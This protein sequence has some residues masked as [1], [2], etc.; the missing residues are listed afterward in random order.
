MPK[1]VRTYVCILAALSFGLSS[2]AG[3]QGPLPACEWQ[4]SHQ[5]LS[6]RASPL[7]SVIL[8]MPT[9]TATICYSRPSARGRSVFD[10]LAPF[11]KVWRTGANEPTTLRLSRKAT[12]G[13]VSLAEEL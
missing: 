8:V 2:S 9:L 10:S 4:G 13:G 1:H 6:T 11:G 12:V 5:W 3:A 7:D